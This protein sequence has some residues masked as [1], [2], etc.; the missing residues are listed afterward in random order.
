MACF[1][2]LLPAELSVESIGGLLWEGRMLRVG[3]VDS[4]PLEAES[5]SFCLFAG[6]HCNWAF[7][8]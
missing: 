5:L 1:S 3:H 8:M 7:Q 6:Q 4:E 2:M